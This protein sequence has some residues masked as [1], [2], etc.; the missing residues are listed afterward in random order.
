MKLPRIVGCALFIAAL[1]FGSQAAAYN[2]DP[3]AFATFK[4]I[5]DTPTLQWTQTPG[6]P[7]GSFS[8]PD[9]GGAPNA[10][11]RFLPGPFMPAHLPEIE[12]LG[13]LAALG[14][15]PTFM[16]ITGT[17]NFQYR[18]GSFGDEYWEGPPAIRAK[19][20]FLYAGDDPL[21]FEGT[22]YLKGAN[23]LTAN[24]TY[25]SVLGGGLLN[26][27]YTSDLGLVGGFKSVY[28]GG[29]TELSIDPV[30]R[31]A[32]Y[33]PSVDN[34]SA[35][36]SGYFTG[37]VPEPST[38]AMMIIGFGAVGSMVRTSRRRSGIMHP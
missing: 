30:L 11:L 8:T 22:E 33:W 7:Q 37:G 15:I 5:G 14:D 17:G 4:S 38:W 31:P 16:T 35:Q 21:L 3:V 36:I 10:S 24:V 27:W 25:M 12:A 34:Y 23:L 18:F 19:F 2:P 13:Q 29:E 1:A 20:T 6:L 26:A 9:S 28:Q 32:H